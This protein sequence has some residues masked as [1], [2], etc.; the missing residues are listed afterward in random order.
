MAKLTKGHTYA[1]NA[2]VSADNLGA[3]IMSATITLVDRSSVEQTNYTLA[4]RG[5]SQPPGPYA[6]ELWQDSTDAH[7]LLKSHRAGIH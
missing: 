4:T 1:A 6:G 5:T 2:T 7:Y 3:L